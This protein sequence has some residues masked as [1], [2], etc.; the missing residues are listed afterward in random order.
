MTE[1]VPS[2]STDAGETLI[3]V[4]HAARRLMD[5]ALSEH[6]MSVSRLK[7]L[8]VLDQAGP[9]RMSTIAAELD[10]AVRSAMDAVASL[11]RDGMLTRKDDP[12]DRRAVL[13]VI[14]PAGRTAM[15]K[16]LRV[17]ERILDETFGTLSLD[18]R[19]QLLALLTKV[20]TAISPAPRKRLRG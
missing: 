8:L 10:I 9:A 5:Q 2:S 12:T 20:R 17:K 7:L 3:T 1:R 6:A 18:E 15:R 14:S 16:A 4:Y 11:E 13:A 19:D